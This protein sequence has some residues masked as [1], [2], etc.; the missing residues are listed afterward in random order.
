VEVL[1]GIEY[2]LLNEFKLKGVVGC[3][4]V[5]MKKDKKRLEAEDGGLKNREEW[6]LET[7]G[8]SLKEVLYMDSIDFTRTFSNSVMEMFDCLGVEASRMSIIK[9]IKMILDVYGIYIN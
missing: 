9:E 7:D 2:K 4:K 6:L 8:S 5:F 1:R 3:K